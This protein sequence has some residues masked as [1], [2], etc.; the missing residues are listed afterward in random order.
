MIDP[1]SI[2]DVL[3]EI[4]D[5]EEEEVNPHFEER[6]EIPCPRNTPDH[7]VTDGDPDEQ[8]FEYVLF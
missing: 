6:E 8:E 5:S 7:R 2:D 1:D 4:I 3:D